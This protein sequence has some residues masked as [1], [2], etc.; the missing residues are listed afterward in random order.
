M[1]NNDSIFSD[2]E[3]LEA[4]VTAVNFEDDDMADDA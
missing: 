1:A 2:A 4:G 3:E